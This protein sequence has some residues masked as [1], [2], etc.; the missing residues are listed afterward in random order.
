MNMS[1]AGLLLTICV[2]VL[3]IGDLCFVLI[4]GAPSSVSDFMIRAGFHA[5]MMVFAFGFVAGHIF[6]AMKLEPTRAT[7]EELDEMCKNR[8]WEKK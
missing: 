5:P 7:E 2:I 3:G 4:T 1:I 6:G 8:G